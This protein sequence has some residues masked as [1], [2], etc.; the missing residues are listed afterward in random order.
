MLGK[1]TKHEFLTIGKVALPSYIAVLV[2]SVIGRFLTWITS[3][4]Y[5]IDN[6]PQ[7]FVRIIK[8]LSSLISTLYILA[9]IALIILTLFYIIYRFY[10]NFYTDEGYLMLTLPVR[11]ASLITSKL[12]NSWIWILFSLIIAFLSLFITLGHYDQ[13]IDLVKRV[14]DSIS[15]VIEVNGDFLRDELGVPLW[16]FGVEVAFCIF[17]FVTRFVITWYSSVS[18]GML[19]SKKHKALGTIGGYIIIDIATWIIMSIYLAVI[20]KVVPDYYTILS[21]S[22][23]KALQIVILGSIV[24]NLIFS[25]V[26]FWFNSFIMTHKLNLD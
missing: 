6:V 26:L 5:I 18:F 19:I 2:L 14:Y 8:V 25:G 12:F 22:G 21:T 9:F 16:L 7:T 1:L 15:N 24:I 13:L 20:T 3:R 23:G 4:Q 17:M 10:K 11:P